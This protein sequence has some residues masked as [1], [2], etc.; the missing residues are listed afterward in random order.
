MIDYLISAFEYVI[1]FDSHLAEIVTKYQHLTYLILFI[2]FFCETG[3]IVT[4]FLP[5]DTLLFA[6]GTITTYEGN[7]LNI[8]TVILLLIAATIL[9]DNTNFLIG[10]FFGHK[11]YSSNSRFIKKKYV[12]KTHTFF[13]KYGSITLVFARFMPIV[14]TF[15]PFAAGIGD[16]NY[17]RFFAFSVIGNV[18]WVVFFTTLGYFF[19]NISLFKDNFLFMIGVVSLISVLPALITIIKKLLKP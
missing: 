12:D 8:F 2:I 1:N 4:P 9:G 6:I 16:M 3:L 17:R 19:G 13:E 18:T 14:R 7:P 5:G 10:R 11:L 15:A